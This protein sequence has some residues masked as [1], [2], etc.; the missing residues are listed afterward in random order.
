MFRASGVYGNKGKIDI[1]GSNAGQVNLGFQ[2][3]PSNICIAIFIVLQVDTV[4]HFKGTDHPV[5]DTLVEIVAALAV[6]T[7]SSQN[8]RTPSPISMMETSKVPPLYTITF[9]S[10]SLSMP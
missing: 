7:S 4:L 3:L 9:W 1:G 6:V 10:S 5:D 8:L 2:R